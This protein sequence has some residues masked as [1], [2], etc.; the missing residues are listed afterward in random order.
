MVRLLTDP[1]SRLAQRI[2][3]DRDWVLMVVA[4]IIGLAMGTVAIAFLWPL[5][6]MEE[7]V[8][9]PGD[10][11]HGGT[12][13]LAWWLLMVLPVVG[14]LLTGVVRHLIHDESQMPGVSSVMYS[15]H[16]LRARMPMKIAVR[17]WLGSTLTIASGG[18][19]GAEGPIV[20]I[21][22][23]IGSNVGQWLRA[24]PQNTAT[25]LGCGAAAG[26]SAVF[27][28]PFA[29]IFF[30]L[31]ILLR[32]FSLRTFAPIVI[33][34]VVSA[35]W[36]RG[37]VGSDAV[38]SVDPAHFTEQ[39]Q[40]TVLQIPNYLLLGLV[41]GMVAVAFVRGLALAER[42]FSKLPVHPVLRPMIGAILLVGL[43]FA[44]L[45]VLG[46]VG[47]R[48]P[49]Y[50]NGYPEVQRLLEPVHYV[51]PT[52][53]E[54]R[55]AGHFLIGLLMIGL[56]KALATCLTHG[57]GGMGGLFAPSLLI[58]A[59]AGGSFG[60]I[61][62]HLGWFPAASPA[63]YAIVGMASVVATVTHAPLTAILIVYEVTRSYELILPLMFAAVISTLIG[64][65]IE[66]ES[67]YTSWL[68]KSGLTVGA[69]SD[70]TILRRLSVSEIPLT[71]AV[72][73]RVDD[74]AARLLKLSE[75][76]HLSD[77]VVVDDHG[78]YIGMVTGND[79]R[80]ALVY[81]DAIPL[82]QVSELVR[83]DLPTV[84]PDESFDVVLSKFSVHDVTSLPVMEP[85]GDGAVL[86]LIT[87]GKLLTKYQRELSQR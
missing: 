84:S 26:I 39:D 2:G 71:K 53:G 22:S 10:D 44:Y 24:N 69:L 73:V 60:F 79:L 55:T 15:I 87:R 86:G 78:N 62:N 59:A 27:N 14:G 23:V 76:T 5:H 7:L 8:H 47:E 40:L 38:F 20:T 6:A 50:G 25:L 66:R 34:S 42:N 28:A 77:F 83:S 72:T 57:S 13:R 18:S 16:R 85:T 81:R 4:A 41:C 12:P 75:N 11:A 46:A 43:G 58:G 80:A 32:D 52:T 30:V 56:V 49:F 64:R 45:A 51:D 17:K 19:A 65:L 70:Q 35:A 21:G 63:T 3:L 61:V 74:S 48:P 37:F 68:A 54:L 33:S 36:A 1:H 82:L 9:D 31:E 29:G 67:I